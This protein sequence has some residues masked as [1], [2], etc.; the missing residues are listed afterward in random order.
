MKILL[1]TPTHKISVPDGVTVGPASIRRI[2]TKA[3]FRRLTFQERK[4]LRLSQLDAV[5][6]LREDLQRGT[7][8]ELDSVLEQ[9]LLDT[10]LIQQS[11]VDALLVD[12]TPE[13]IQL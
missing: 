7:F 3:F 1:D 12:G 9:Q 4:V 8:V 10:T 13:E 5:A 6:D 11:R 2:T